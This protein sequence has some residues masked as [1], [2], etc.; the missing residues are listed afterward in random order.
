VG[1]VLPCY[2]RTASRILTIARLLL[3]LMGVIFAV[4][5]GYLV[6]ERRGPMKK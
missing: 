1:T 3:V 6:L 5:G 4:H 2:G